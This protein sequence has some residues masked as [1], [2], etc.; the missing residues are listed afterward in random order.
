MQLLRVLRHLNGQ[1]G[2][3][4]KEGKKSWCQ[5][6]V[7]C[8]IPFNNNKARNAPIVLSFIFKTEGMVTQQLTQIIKFLNFSF[9]SP[10]MKLL[11][12][13]IGLSTFA[14]LQI[15]MLC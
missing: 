13:K 6:L 8:F 10:T 2:D 14:R 5:V 15:A 12:L 1:S 9:G 7:K 3:T 4:L 11:I